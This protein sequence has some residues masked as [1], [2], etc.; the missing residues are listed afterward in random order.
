VAF[1]VVGSLLLAACGDPASVPDTS[2]AVEEEAPMD[3]LELDVGPHGF[4]VSDTTVEGEWFA[5]AGVHGAIVHEGRLHGRIRGDEPVLWTRDA[6]GAFVGVE[7]QISRVAET[8]AAAVAAAFRAACRPGSGA[9]GDARSGLLAMLRTVGDTPVGPPPDPLPPTARAAEVRESPLERDVPLLGWAPA[10]RSVV[11]FRSIEAAFRFADVID[12]VAERIGFTHGVAVDHGSVRLTLHHLLLPSIWGAN[13]GGPK[14]VSECLLVLGPQSPG[15]VNAALV[16]RIV[17]PE[18]HTMETVAGVALETSPDH[19][20]R[21]EGDPFPERRVRRAVRAI[22]GDCEVVATGPEML[23]EVLAA[24]ERGRAE[25]LGELARRVGLPEPPGRKRALSFRTPDGAPFAYAADWDQRATRS[26]Y[27][28][29]ALA[30]RFSGLRHPIDVDPRQYGGPSPGPEPW[31]SIVAA[32]V[33]T[34][35]DGARVAVRMRD[36]GTAR[37]LGE[38]LSAEPITPDASRQL[39]GENLL[40][41]VPLGMVEPRASDVAERCFVW[42]G[43]RPVCPDGGTYRFHPVTGEPRRSR[44]TVRS[45]RSC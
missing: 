38:I 11:L 19:L 43:F 16:L 28:V 14:G 15:N 36:E 9:I 1:G 37:E 5:G 17:D 33:D 13:P 4:F 30:E 3:V 24:A 41:L 34:G 21:P 40:K 42:L 26:F 6:D 12:R 32:C 7:P 35:I 25:T 27:G 10:G 39:C 18:L 44:W 2:A 45:S 23:E 29:K 22:V 8:Q 31:R 20:W